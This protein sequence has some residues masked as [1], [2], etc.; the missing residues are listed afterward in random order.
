[1]GSDAPVGSVDDSAAV[2]D[3]VPIILIIFVTV[4]AAISMMIFSCI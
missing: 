3:A 1:M 4:S 2:F